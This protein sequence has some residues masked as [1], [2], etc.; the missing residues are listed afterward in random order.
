[1]LNAAP[2]E[3]A[4]RIAQKLMLH[5]QGLAAGMNG[6]PDLPITKTPPGL[7]DYITA[8]VLLA[9]LLSLVWMVVRATNV[10]PGP[11]GAME[12][13]AVG[14]IWVVLFLLVSLVGLQSTQAP[15]RSP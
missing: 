2:E 11:A 9:G 14:A 12:V 13:A 8:G 6:P 4:A 10:L 15:R 1:V 5:D 7:Q 3:V